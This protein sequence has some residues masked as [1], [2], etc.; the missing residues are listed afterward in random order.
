LARRVLL[1]ASELGEES[2]ILD[3]ISYALR[4]G[5]FRGYEGPIKR[6]GLMAKLDGNPRAMTLLA[7]LL[8]AQGENKEALNWVQKATRGASG[9][10][11]EEAGEAL[12][13]EGRLLQALNNKEEAEFAFRKAAFELDDP[14]AYFYLSQLHRHD[15][16]R[17]QVYLL[18]AA[19]SG[20]VEAWHNL[21]SMEL[22]RL[23]SSKANS[24]SDYGMA[25]EWFA[26]AAA[27]G[28]G[29]SMINLAQICK[30]GGQLEEGLMW[31]EK[32]K[33]LPEVR[34]EALSMKSAWTVSENL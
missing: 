12:V 5:D 9:V 17:Q 15:S 21:G 18:K 33:E 4:K 6:L 16:S 34:E 22:A 28:F 3:L 31:L 14:S 26:I 24:S 23:D 7:R 32:A 8:Y 20:I 19:S 11:F 29:P 27:D 13:N 25:R 30:A 2:A 1:S 10:D